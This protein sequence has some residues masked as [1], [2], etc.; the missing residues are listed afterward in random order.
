MSL[1]YVLNCHRYFSL[2]NSAISENEFLDSHD[3]RQYK[4][5]LKIL[6]SR[7]IHRNVAV[8]H[9]PSVL[10]PPQSSPCHQLLMAVVQDC[11]NRVI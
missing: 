4:G 2:S 11:M 6:C 10:A 9:V 8:S 5:S 3:R 1:E 7:Q